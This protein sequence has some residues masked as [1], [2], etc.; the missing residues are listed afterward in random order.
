MGI[1]AKQYQTLMSPLRASRVA[2]RAQ[3]GKQLSYLEAWDVKAHLT[4]VFGFGNWDA[5]MLEYSHVTDRPYM[6]EP[7][8]GG[9]P[10]PMVEVI[11]S[12]RLRLT[13]RDPEG[14]FLCT[15]IEA[16][17]GSASGPANMLGEHHDNALK[18]AASDALK[19]CAINLGT[20]FGLSLYDDG[21]LTD[22]IRACLVVPEGVEAEASPTPQPNEEQAATLVRSLGATEVKDDGGDDY[23][24]P[25]G[26]DDSPDQ[27]VHQHD[28]GLG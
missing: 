16:A 5:E 14:Q 4:R 15:H 1:T 24:T 23:V 2:K 25:E 8:N 20:Q 3:G 18:T 28:G 13:I 11:Y 12:A 6:S 26:Y 21:R 22:V 7:R 17:V 10:K 9:E 27:G 19:R